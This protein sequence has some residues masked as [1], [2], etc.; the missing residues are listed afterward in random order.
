VIKPEMVAN[1]TVV[2]RILDEVVVVPQD[3]LVRV[4]E[5]YVVF[6]V[7]GSEGGE[8]AAVRAVELGPSQGNRVVIRQGL[9]PGDRLVVVGHKQLA[10]GDRVRVVG[11]E[12]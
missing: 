9:E 10:D 12:G 4:A 1:V 11:G 5:G 8:A 2:R 3:A 7:E 6:V